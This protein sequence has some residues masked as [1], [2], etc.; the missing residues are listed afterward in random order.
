M[1]LTYVRGRSAFE[2]QSLA[3]KLG[4][5]LAIGIVVAVILAFIDFGQ[6]GPTGIAAIIVGLPCALSIPLVWTPLKLVANVREISEVKNG[7]TTLRDAHQDVQELE[8][9]TFRLLR[10][11]GE[12]YLSPEQRHDRLSGDGSQIP[13]IAVATRSGKPGIRLSAGE[14]VVTIISAVCLTIGLAAKLLS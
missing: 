7:Y 13:A 11:P 9:A 4:R 2:L 8:P 10:Q 14:R 3:L 12:P 6:R 5:Y 1:N